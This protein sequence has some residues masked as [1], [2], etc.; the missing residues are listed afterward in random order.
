MII[1]IDP[2]HGGSDPGAV[3][4]A[5]TVEKEHT[6]AIALYARELLEKSGHQVIL[7][8]DTD[9]DVAFPEAT[10]SAELRTRV[11]IA[12]QAYAD[13][14]I[15]I[16]INAAASAEA[17]GTE[18][19]YYLGGQAFAAFVQT[20]LSKLGLAD[21]GVKQAN[22]YVLKHTV[23]PAILVEIGFISNP[24]EEQLLATEEFRLNA[25]QTIV[26]GIWSWQNA[27]WQ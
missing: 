24:Q 18:T 1:A 5:G 10:A 22:F 21:R 2:G 6:L 12:N 23:M 17:H 8:R 25:A 20:A 3:G 16:H 4:P 9:Q 19:W 26:D 11:D 7:T 13:I 14:F 27:T 15:S